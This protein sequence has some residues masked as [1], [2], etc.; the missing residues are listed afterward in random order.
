MPSFRVFRVFR[1]Y[2]PLIRLKIEYPR[3]V[4]NPQPQASEACALSN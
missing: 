1:G 3:R 2:I 4:S